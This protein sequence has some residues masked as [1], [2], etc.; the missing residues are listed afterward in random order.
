MKLP[1]HCWFNRR[2]FE[3]NGNPTR[4][5]YTA[6]LSKI[7]LLPKKLPFEGIF[8]VGFCE[9]DADVDAEWAYRPDGSNVR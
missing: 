7:E 9:S 4:L 8:R 1:L 5:G 3:S 2:D 6:V